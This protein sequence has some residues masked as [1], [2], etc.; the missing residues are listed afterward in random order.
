MGIAIRA[1]SQAERPR[2]R[3]AGTVQA[4]RNERIGGMPALEAEVQP[5]HGR[6][7]LGQVDLVW[8]GRAGIP[9]IE[10]GATV[11]AEGRLVVR[12]GRTTM[13]NPRY[14]LRFAV[15]SEHEPNEP[16]SAVA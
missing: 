15:T 3:I 4:I 2:V 16:V 8:L 11:V 7:D 13:F 12:R 5:G 6:P 14:E 1:S 9:G 10:P